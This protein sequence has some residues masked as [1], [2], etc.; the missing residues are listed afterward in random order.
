MMNKQIT[1]ITVLLLTTMLIGCQQT[2]TI[3]SANEIANLTDNDIM[4][5]NAQTCAYQDK[6]SIIA[7]ANHPLQQ[8]LND[9]KPQL[10]S[11]INGQ[12]ISYHIY[13]NIEP[14]AWSTLNGCVRL[15]SGLMKLLDDNE[16]MAVIGHELGHIDL[17]HSLATFKHAKELEI[18]QS[19]ELSLLL[20][21]S[22]SQQ[23]EL[24][25]D[26]YAIQFL[27]DRNIDPHYLLT[28]LDKVSAYQN[29]RQGTHPDLQLRKNNL[30]N[31]INQLSS[32]L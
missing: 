20:S 18:S 8:R 17:Q 12:V 19:G 30:S 27:V 23:Q 26:D 31:K 28:M 16:L 14:Y 5:F 9:L 6:H 4:Q 11:N 15:N 13:L 2:K 24:I 1:T 21:A 29:K 25:A 32:K 10:P 22:L 7:N 3:L